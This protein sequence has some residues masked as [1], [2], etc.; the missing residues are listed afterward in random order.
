MEA[1]RTATTTAEAPQP[2]VLLLPPPPSSNTRAYMTYDP[3]ALRGVPR[4]SWHAPR[5]ATPSASSSAQVDAG[6]PFHGAPPVGDTPHG[7][8]GLTPAAANRRMQA[9]AQRWL[10][11]SASTGVVGGAAW[12]TAW[13]SCIDDGPAPPPYTSLPYARPPADV[14]KGDAHLRQD[15]VAAVPWPLRWSWTSG[16]ASP[17]DEHDLASSTPRLE[18]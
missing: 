3:W 5:D 11:A 7:A 2:L 8:H 10:E 18:S 14:G 6:V 15:T 9:I 17:H 1:T 13:A 16:L 4:M 12:R